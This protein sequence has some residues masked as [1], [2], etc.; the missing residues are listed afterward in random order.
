MR[1][2]IPGRS[3]AAMASFNILM[4]IVNEMMRAHPQY[5]RTI[6]IIHEDNSSDVAIDILMALHAYNA[7]VLFVNLDGSR[8][9]QP[10]RVEDLGYYIFTI[11]VL[12]DVTNET[13]LRKMYEHMALGS[14]HLYL[15]FILQKAERHEIEA[16]F[17][18]QFEHSVLRTGAC[19]LGK[20]IDIYTHCAYK[21]QFAVKVLE[22]NRATKTWPPDLFKTVF[23]GKD[24]Y[25]SNSSLKI[26]IAEDIPKAFRLPSRYRLTYLKFYFS[27]I[28]GFSARLA[29]DRMRANFKY[30]TVS[31]TYVTKIAHFMPV[32]GALD[33]NLY[34]IPINFN[35]LKPDSLT[36]VNLSADEPLS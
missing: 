23:M 25:L 10:I 20:S 5:C 1:L 16:F 11:C 15:N 32:N 30:R 3:A 18:G 17:R 7:P 27:G 33:R 21:Q 36:Y 4:S 24:L 31:D 6:A 26:F 2:A 14:H 13:T 29:E 35:D 34:G 9:I 28:D 12:V 8:T 22:I 19:F